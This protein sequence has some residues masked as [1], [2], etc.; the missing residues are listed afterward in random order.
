KVLW[1]GKT[2]VREVIRL[3]WLA[4][5]K[6]GFL[7]VTPEHRI[8]MAS[9]EYVEAR[10]LVSGDYRTPDANKR[11]PKR[12][13]L[14][15]GREGDKVFQ[16][17]RKITKV[18]FIKNV[19]DV[20]DLE[21]EEHHNFIANKIC[22]HNSSD[23]PNF[24]NLPIRNPKMAKIIRSAFIPRSDRHVLVEIDYSGI[25]V[26]VAACYHKDPV[27]IEY[28]NDPTKDMHR[29]MAAQ[30]YLAPPEQVSKQ[31]RYCGKNMY[32]FPQFY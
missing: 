9:G 5:G 30:C 24:Q 11:T 25:E 17:N 16:T 6:K 19:V 7:D 10:K 32:V 8:R 23:S 21:V 14:A 29:D 2:G 1:A 26:R 12:Q 18:E 20:Y 22:V 13:V 27:M 4:Q 3:H 31:M 28:I 15:M